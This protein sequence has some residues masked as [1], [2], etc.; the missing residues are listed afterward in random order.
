MS[1]LLLIVIPILWIVA[2][3]QEGDDVFGTYKG[4]QKFGIGQTESPVTFEFHGQL[5][6]ISGAIT[7]PGSSTLVAVVVLDYLGTSTRFSR[8]DNN[9]TYI[10]NVSFQN[11]T[12]QG[13]FEPLG[14]SNPS[15]GEICPSDSDGSFTAQKQ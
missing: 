1:R 8:K 3:N 7:P 6:T 4:T 11:G 13:T 9:I 10:Y 12:A 2:C 5:N 14:C 15:S